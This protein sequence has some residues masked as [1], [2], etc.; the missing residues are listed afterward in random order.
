MLICKNCNNK[1]NKNKYIQDKQNKKN[2]IKICSKCKLEKS[3]EDFITNSN[4]CHCCRK[5]W[6]DENYKN[7]YLFANAKR[8]A[9]RDGLEFNLIV[10]DIVITEICPYI[11]IKLEKS[12]IGYTNNSV[13]LDR[14]NNNYGYIKNNIMV[15]SRQANMMKGNLTIEQIKL[16]NYNFYEKPTIAEIVNYNI[17]NN[18]TDAKIRAKKH[19]IE[20]NISETDII[21]TKKCPLLN[22]DLYKSKFKLGENS[23][24]LDRID[25]NK[26][27]IPDNVRIISYKANRS[28]NNSTKEEYNLLTINLSNI[29]EKRFTK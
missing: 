14:I 9:K 12:T 8:R 24:T 1:N 28:K 19:N 17:K 16:I 7:Q 27:Y 18:L 6:H 13:T 4:I 3:G 10:D 29:L 15:V 26:G 21:L 22:I 2:I 11:N 25:N 20:F 5:I 23:P